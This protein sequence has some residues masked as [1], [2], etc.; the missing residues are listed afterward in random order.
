VTK[1]FN[2]I[3]WAGGFIM[4]S[5]LGAMGVAGGILLLVLILI[6]AITVAAVRRGESAME[7]LDKK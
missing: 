4:S 1:R 7:E 5:A 2:G 3:L 6:V